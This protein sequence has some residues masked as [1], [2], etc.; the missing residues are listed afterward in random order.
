MLPSSFDL[1]LALCAFVEGAGREL[2]T[3]GKQT[4]LIDSSVKALFLPVSLS[5]SPVL[6]RP[7]HSFLPFLLLESGVKNETSFVLWTLMLSYYTFL[8]SGCVDGL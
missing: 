8:V 4:S 7:N 5:I 1:P 6:G 2:Q 3:A